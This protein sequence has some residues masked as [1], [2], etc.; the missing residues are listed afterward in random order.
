M[1]GHGPAVIGQEAFDAQEEIRRSRSDIYGP[2]VLDPN[3]GAEPDPNDETGLRSAPPAGTSRKPHPGVSDA[4][5][6][7]ESGESASEAD[8]TP[9]EVPAEN[10]PFMVSV[11]ELRKQLKANPLLV[12]DFQRAELQRPGGLRSS[13]IE[14]MLDAEKRRTD[15]QGGARPEVIESLGSMLAT[16]SQ[17]KG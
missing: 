9:P 14:V 10:Q 5:Y 11:R 1:S 16:A 3:Y 13:A 17:Q 8:E 7:D 12:D 15:V 6:E 4:A 2:A